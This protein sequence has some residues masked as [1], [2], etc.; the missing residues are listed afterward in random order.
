MAGTGVLIYISLYERMVRVVGDDPIAEKLVQTDWDEI[1]DLVT[2]GLRED[3]A[4][5]GLVAAIER[6]GTL[7]GAHFPPLANAP[8]ELSNELRILD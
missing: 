1:R 8:D 6:C 2:A 5:A 7:C 4:C 3:H